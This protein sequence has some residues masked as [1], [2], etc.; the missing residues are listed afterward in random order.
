MNNKQFK[1]ISI[2]TALYVLLI[3][4]MGCKNEN[5]KTENSIE[6]NS[7]KT[8]SQKVVYASDVNSYF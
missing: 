5:K 3:F 2:I 8:K 7:S 6:A 4:S 1:S